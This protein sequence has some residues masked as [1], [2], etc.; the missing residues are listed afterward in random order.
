MWRDIVDI[1]GKKMVEIVDSHAEET[2]IVQSLYKMEC[3]HQNIYLRL[4]LVHER[5]IRT[6]R[7][8]FYSTLFMSR[9]ECVVHFYFFDIVH[10]NAGEKNLALFLASCCPPLFLFACC[11]SN[12]RHV[13]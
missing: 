11:S 5:S 4:L 3:F 8:A 10:P 1:L 7:F 9:S 12:I 13:L 6:L 2:F